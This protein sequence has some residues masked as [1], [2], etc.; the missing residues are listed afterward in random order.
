MGQKWK[1]SQLGG[2]LL[3]INATIGRSP[4]RPEKEVMGRR[5]GHVFLNVLLR[6]QAKSGW[7]KRE[8]GARDADGG[9]ERGIEEKNYQKKEPH[10]ERQEPALSILTGS[11]DT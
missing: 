8:G 9:T 2:S 5:K 1:K 6:S 7:R 10:G 4:R 3:K 11:A